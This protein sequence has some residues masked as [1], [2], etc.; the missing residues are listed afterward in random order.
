[1][2]QATALSKIGVRA[3]DLKAQIDALITGGKVIESITPINH[4]KDGYLIVYH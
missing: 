2:A 1:M 4:G 3:V